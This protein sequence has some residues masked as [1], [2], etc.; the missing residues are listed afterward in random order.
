MGGSK[1]YLFTEVNM[2]KKLV[3]E[4]PSWLRIRLG[5][6]KFRVCSLALL[7]G[8]R[9]QHCSELWYRLQTR[10]GSHVAVALVQAWIRPLAWEP[11][12]ATGAAQ[13]MA[14]RPKKKKSQTNKQNQLSGVKKLTFFLDE[15]II[16]GVCKLGQVKR[17]RLYPY[18]VI[19]ISLFFKT[20]KRGRVEGLGSCPG[21]HIQCFGPCLCGKRK[22]WNSMESNVEM[23]KSL[24]EVGEEVKTVFCPPK[25]G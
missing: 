10:L 6:M 9:I 13:E 2:P 23:W 16:F 7:R 19:Q 25:F 15:P 11:P 3:Q 17:L 14:K 1:R 22:E 18:S 24:K 12:Y 20:D 21:P 8:L 5:T 4:F